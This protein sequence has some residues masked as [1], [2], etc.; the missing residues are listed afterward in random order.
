MRKREGGTSAGCAKLP[1]KSSQLEARSTS[2]KETGAGSA[3][4]DFFT[5]QTANIAKKSASR[6]EKRTQVDKKQKKK[7]GKKR[8]RSGVD[9]LDDI[10]SGLV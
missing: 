2:D 8:R 4:I 10:F 5:D 1:K 3:G 9:E 6:S 7:G